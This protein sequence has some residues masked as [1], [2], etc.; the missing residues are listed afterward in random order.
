MRRR[1]PTYVVHL[2]ARPD[3]SIHDLRRAL[4]TFRK[5]G[6]RCTHFTETLSPPIGARRRKS[7]QERLENTNMDM[8]K[9]RGEHFIKLAD[10]ADGPLDE[11][12]AAVR[13]GKYGKPDAVFE[14]GDVLSLNAT[15]VTALS[16][17]YGDDSDGWNGKDVQLYQ[18]EVSF[19]GQ[20]Q[21]AVRVKPITPSITAA[22]KAEAVKKLAQDLDDEIP[23]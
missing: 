6:L 4:K 19:E 13:E 1:G 18:G 23:Y 15:N 22:A 10:V 20:P 11:R 8:R 9:F 12:I 16:R 17:A 5:L 2:Q 3:G 7:K 21:D 14:S